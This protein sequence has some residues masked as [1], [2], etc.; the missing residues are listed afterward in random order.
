ML[1]ITVSRT[2]PSRRGA[3]WRITPSF[4][5]PSASIAACEVKLKPSVRKP[6]TRQPRTSKAWPSS[7]H[8]QAVFTFV[9]WQRRAYH[10]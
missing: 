7:S 3:W 5:A 4:L 8:L 10:V 2:V 6:T 1:Y 9:F